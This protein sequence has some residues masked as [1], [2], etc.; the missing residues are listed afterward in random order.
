[1]P[2]YDPQ[3]GFDDFNG[4]QSR[5]GRGVA[6]GLVLKCCVPGT[7]DWLASRLIRLIYEQSDEVGKFKS[8]PRLDICC[9]ALF[10]LSMV[11]I[12]GCIE[13]KNLRWVERCVSRT[14]STAVIA[15]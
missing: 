3:Q 12:R 13:E 10:S 2:P 9:Q 14:F 1:M 6:D 7:D 15:L 4:R 5:L 8:S 11:C